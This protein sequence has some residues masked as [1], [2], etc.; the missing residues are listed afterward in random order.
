[1]VVKG[2]VTPA[3]TIGTQPLLFLPAQV[4][5]KKLTILIFG[6]GRRLEHKVGH[7]HD[8]PAPPPSA[9]EH[10]TFQ[11]FWTYRILVHVIVR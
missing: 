6:E 5:E 10:H 4:G 3:V 9:S 2:C 7:G 1:M 8:I 11:I